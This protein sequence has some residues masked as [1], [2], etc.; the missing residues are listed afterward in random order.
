[1]ASLPRGD[2]KPGNRQ[3]GREQ[4]G[5]QSGSSIIEFIFLVVLLLVPL[6]YLVVGAAQVQAA[7]YAAVGAADHAAKVF[8]TAQSEGQGRARAADA[9]QRA[10]ANMQIGPGRTNFS[11]S[12]QG[13]CL[14]AGSTVTVR[15][16]IET[17]LPLLPQ[18]WSW[19]TGNVGSN[20]TQR[21]DRY[22]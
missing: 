7:S 3:A 20:A 2:V 10:A 1:M 9:V 15:V 19:R 5:P 18:G 17:V 13:T 4:H 6:V 8:V 14:S 16:S 12:C 11:Y 22:G 21:V